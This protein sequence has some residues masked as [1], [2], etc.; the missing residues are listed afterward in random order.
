MSEGKLAEELARGAAAESELRLTAEAFARL[1]A[2]YVKAWEATGARDSDAR[3]RLWQA[4]QI[5][6]KVEAHLRALV[7]TGKLAAR[8]LE[9][10]ERLGERRKILGII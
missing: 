7:D 4:V 2:D 10:I 6:G 1:R 5:V 8:Q 3:E 9:D